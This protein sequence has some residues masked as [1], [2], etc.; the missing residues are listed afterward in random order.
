MKHFLKALLLLLFGCN[1]TL[2]VQAQTISYKVNLGNHKDLNKVVA[3]QLE[4]TVN[5]EALGRNELTFAMPAMVPGIYAKLDFGRLVSGI[6]AQSVAG[7]AEVIKTSTNT[8]QIRG[9]API[10]SI[11]YWVDD[12]WDDCR[13]VEQPTP[14]YRSA[15][16]CFI[17]DSAFLI[18]ANAV[19][20]YV[21]GAEKSPLVLNLT[22]PTEMLPVSGLKAKATTVGKALTTWQLKAPN[23]RTFVDNPILV[24]APDTTSFHVGNLRVMIA[25]FSRGGLKSAATLA[26]VIEPLV[27]AQA[28]YLG[29][30]LQVD[31]YT[32]LNYHELHHDT[33]E[34]Y[35]DGL[36]HG[37]STLIINKIANR[38]SVIKRQAFAVANHEFYH[39]LMPLNLH[40]RS[41]EDYDFL[42]PAPSAHLWLYEGMTEYFTWH[43]RLSQHLDTPTQSLE[44]LSS[45]IRQASRFD[46]TQSLWQMSLKASTRQDQYMNF[47]AKGPLLCLMLD[48]E[49][50]KSSNGL[51][52]NRKLVA[53]LTKHFGPTGTF[54]EGELF[55]TI[56]QITKL[57]HL[58]QWLTDYIVENKPL[59]LQRYLSLIGL[60]IK[61]NQTVVMVEKAGAEQVGLYGVWGR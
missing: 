36:E 11:S 42:N 44:G 3:D 34:Y 54:E 13:Q 18:N 7:P 29:G 24:A 48:L 32:F 27:Q 33:N 37:Q 50:I 12:S 14:V 23:Y 61:A 22:A 53:A 21:V 46:S 1:V 30:T 2:M 10:K 31:R 17:A 47:Y 59:P 41:I 57:P 45:Y 56:A 26:S 5:V 6:S 28:K 58:R 20:G 51:W 38:P 19:F 8:W 35:Y 4:V 16:S 43:T 25:G 9:W 40:S 52:N 49:L 55:S 39:I 60:E 15:G